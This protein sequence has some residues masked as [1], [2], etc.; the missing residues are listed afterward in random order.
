MDLDTL[1]V[2]VFCQVDDS[3]RDLLDDRRLRQRGPL[4]ALTDAES[5]TIELIGE[6]LSLDCDRAIFDYFRRHFSH[7][8]PALRH[9]HRTSFARQS[10][11]LWKVKERLWQH[12]VKEID[13]DPRL[14]LIDSFALPTCRFARANR[15]LRLRS[16]SE[17]GFDEM[18]KQTFFG[19]RFHL[20]VSF[21]GVIT[22]VAVEAA[23]VHELTVA[24]ELLATKSGWVI[25]DRNYYSPGLGEKLASHGLRLIAPFRSRKR[26]RKPFPSWLT[27]LRRRI[28][29]VIGQLVE[30]FNTR[31]VWARDAWHFYARLLR[32]ILAHTVFVGLCQRFDLRPLRMAALLNN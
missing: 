8:F 9:I 17:Y 19:V 25:G 3:L 1:I 32:K 6:Y 15:C 7:F 13:F 10:A 21:P 12:L 30:R 18:A 28:E 2:T 26:E 24:E 11:N 20:R 4:P 23:N 29:T 16:I 22:A 14:S 31:R 5:L 27:C